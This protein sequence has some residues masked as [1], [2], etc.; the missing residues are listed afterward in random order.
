MMTEIPCPALNRKAATEGLGE[1]RRRFRTRETA[2]FFYPFLGQFSGRSVDSGNRPL[3]N[4][5][6]GEG[7]TGTCLVT[8]RFQYRDLMGVCQSPMR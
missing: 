3:L 8:L 2:Q 5:F 4:T 1:A 7:L 6:I